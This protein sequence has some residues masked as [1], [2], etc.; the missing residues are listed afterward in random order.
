MSTLYAIHP[1]LPDLF[2]RYAALVAVFLIV[3]FGLS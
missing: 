1:A 3:L 2:E